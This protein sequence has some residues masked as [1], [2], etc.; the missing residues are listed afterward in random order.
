[1]DS[2]LYNEIVSD[3]KNKNKTVDDISWIGTIEKLYDTEKFLS[4]AKKINYDPGYGGEEISQD[5]L[6]VG[7]DFWLERHEYDGSEW[8][9]YKT[10]PSKPVIHVNVN[11]EEIKY[12]W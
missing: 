12:K 7:K 10:L 4:L 9:E 1:M 11:E 6:I 2:N 8:F 5:L 3:L